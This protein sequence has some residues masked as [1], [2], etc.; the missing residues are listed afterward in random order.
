MEMKSREEVLLATG[1]IGYL[2]RKFGIPG[3]VGLLFIGFQPIVDG[4]F[5]GN[6][7]GAEAL[8]G[9]NL[10]MPIYTFMSASAVVAGIGCQTVVS[11]SLGEQK[12]H[13]ANDAFRTAFM[14]LIVYSLVLTIL[15]WVWAEPL[16][17]LLGA[18][19][20]LSPYAKDYIRAFSPFF[21]FLTLVF[22][23]DYI[24]KATGRPYSALFLLGLILL[25]NIVLDYL[26]IVRFGMGVKGAALATGLSLGLSC[27]L[28]FIKLL[29]RGNIV[30]LRAGRLS[31]RLLGQMLYNGSS[32]GVSELS[33][34]VT[35]LLFNWVMM[36]NLG[37]EGVA[38]F[39]AVNYLLYLG[40]QLFV[41][42]SDG[43]IPILSYNYGAGNMQRIRQTLHF[44]FKC[45]ALIGSIFFLLIFFGGDFFIRLFFMDDAN[46][47]IDSILA[48]ASVGADVIAFAFF[49][50][51]ANILASSF[52]TSRG[53]AL[54]SAIISFLR[55]LVL[56][57]IGIMIYPLLF[58]N[59]GIWL[60]IPVAELITAVYCWLAFRKKVS[61]TFK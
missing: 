41:G 29:K 56:I 38:A 51:G 48:I 6:F 25:G 49:L 46:G 43:I 55:G 47:N 35:V 57:V 12:Y 53:D 60:V 34:G 1:R 7:V 16:C 17:V 15:C 13:C 8:A 14:F 58:G 39:T 40:V 22:L 3:I 19:E 50:N 59:N 28:M 44:G 2:F 9:V 30:K 33:A 32:S 21:I 23:G 54:T 4:L 52:F 42:L 26:F 24:L 37:A 36:K 5:L 20:I 61:W 18:D 45:N 27:V 10:F 31:L 11:I